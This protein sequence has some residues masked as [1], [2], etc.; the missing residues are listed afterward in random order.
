M[1]TAI[2]LIAVSGEDTVKSYGP[3][4]TPPTKTK[5]GNVVAEM[6]K[7]PTTGKKSDSTVSILLLQLTDHNYK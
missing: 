7:L 6:R 2:L 4:P 3:G 5:N 1:L